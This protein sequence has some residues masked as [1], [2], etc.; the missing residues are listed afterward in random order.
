MKTGK[1]PNPFLFALYRSSLGIYPKH[2]RLLYQNQLLQTA[3]DAYADSDSSLYFWPS[4]F[5]DLLQSAVKEQL[6]MIR[7]QAIAR[8]IFFHAVT[9][10]II[11]TLFGAFGAFV[12]QGLLRRGANEPQAQMAAL[13]ASEIASGVKPDEAIP[14]N[15]VDLE[16]SLEPFVIFYNDQSEPVT[17]TGYLNQTIPT[18]P[19][20]VFRYLRSHPT[21]TITW[22]PQPG[23]R[24]AA[25][26]HRVSG[27]HPGFLLT[28]RSLRLVEDQEAILRN[29]VFGGWFLIVFLLFAGAILLSRFQQPPTRLVRGG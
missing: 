18:P 4:L 16:R 14:R 28:G 11:L 2:L 20:G 3:R 19:S 8:P 9:L 23:V 12:F 26:I 17:A 6:L 7:D 10:G 15:Y 29:M 5:A 13:Y 22:Q 21:D 24:I 25:V 27:P 1:I